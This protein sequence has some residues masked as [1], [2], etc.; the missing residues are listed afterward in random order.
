MTTRRGFFARLTGLAATG[1]AVKLGQSHDDVPRRVD[2]R[3]DGAN[4]SLDVDI[5]LNGVKQEYAVAYDLDAQTLTRYRRGPDGFPVLSP[6]DQW[7]Q[8]H[9]A[10][11]VRWRTPK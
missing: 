2:M 8:E 7:V 5:F 11:V 4:A 10:V 6:G 3:D 9:G 1:V